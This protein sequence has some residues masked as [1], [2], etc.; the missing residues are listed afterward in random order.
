MPDVA[1]FVR[2]HSARQSLTQVNNG[3]IVELM[4]LQQL[5]AT[6]VQFDSEHWRFYAAYLESF[7]AS[8]AISSIARSP[9]PNVEVGDSEEEI[10]AKQLDILRSYPFIN[11]SIYGSSGG[12]WVEDALL[13]LQNKGAE[14]Y[15]DLLTPYY[16]SQFV[17]LM[18]GGERIGAG[19]VGS[20]QL[21]E[22][23]RVSVRLSWREVVSLLPRPVSEVRGMSAFGVDVE[24]TPTLVLEFNPARKLVWLTNAGS[25]PVFLSF[26][27]ATNVAANQGVYLAPNGGSV[28]YEV[29]RYQIRDA[30]WA[31][32]VGGTTRLTGVQG[33]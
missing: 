9:M 2:S 20:Q 17:Y 18:G 33:Q 13:P 8:V 15:L 6:D 12:V 22:G 23:D 32:A 19:F 14:Y 29:E 1:P 25:A 30:L 31:I 21:G 11:F 26:G 7:R 28:S 10:R 27:D 4:N 5:R 24:Q 16:T 3:H